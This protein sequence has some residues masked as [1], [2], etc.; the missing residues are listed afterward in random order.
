VGSRSSP[1]AE[2]KA[3]GE[4]LENA[5]RRFKNNV[6]QENIVREIQRHSLPLNSGEKK[7][8]KQVLGGKL[9]RKPAKRGLG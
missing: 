8:A 6:E 4:T 3:P 1:L 2:A 7:R 5:L 9:D